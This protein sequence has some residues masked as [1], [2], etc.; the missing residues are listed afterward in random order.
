MRRIRGF[1][2]RL[3]GLLGLRRDDTEL[4][5][6]LEANVALHIEDNIRSGMSPEEARR[7]ALIKWGGLAQTKELYRDR[8]RLPLIEMFFQDVRYGLRMLRKNPGFT[9]VAVLTL[10]LGIGANTAVFSVVRAVLLKSLPYPDPQSLIV[11]NEY[12]VR[13]GE[14]SVSWMDFRDWQEQQ[15]VF[16][17]MAAYRVR[18]FVLTGLEQPDLLR[19]GE[20][21]APFFDL[22]RV[23]PA[24]GRAFGADDD[25]PGANRTVMLSDSFWRSHLNADPA[26]PGRSLILDGEAYTVI[27]ILPADFK[28]LPANIDIFVAAGLLGDDAI[29][30]ERG[31]HEGFEVLA[32]LAPGV[33]LSAARSSMETIMGR[34]EQ[35]YPALD[36]GQRVNLT[37][38]YDARVGDIQR[39][40]WIMLAASF[41]V[42]LI[43]CANV[44]NLSLARAAARARDLAIRGALGARRAR[45]IRQL[46]TENLLLALG[47][48]A[49][50]FVCASWG[51]RPLLL[52]APKS[53]PRLDETRVDMNMFIFALAIALLTGIVFGLLPAWQSSRVDLTSP[54]REAGHRSSTGREGQRLRAVLL[55]A[56]I[57]LA[58]VL[59]T[60]S[61]LLVRSLVRTL[62]VDPGFNA[63]HLLALSVSLPPGKYRTVAQE[64]A[65]LTQALDL[66]R[67]MPGVK[68]A[69]AVSCPPLIGTCWHSVY[70]V[71]DRPAP[72]AAQQPRAAFNIV[73]P[74]YFT[75]MQIPL[76]AGRLFHLS[77][78]Q[79][80]PRVILI[81]ETMA[82]LWWPN[83]SAIG[84]T[85]KQEFPQDKS[86]FM[87]I[88]GV[89]KDLKQEGLD[90]PEW[91]EIFEPVTQ[92]PIRFLT[93][94]VK[95]ANDP[96]S[97]APLVKKAIYQV[98]K[99]QPAYRVQSMD[100]YLAASLA[101][102]K[103]ETLLLGIFSALALLLAAVGVYGLV[104]Y[105]VT[106]RTYEIGIRMALGA[107]KRGI[108]ALVL[109]FGLKLA[110]CGVAIGLAVSFVAT[111][112]L[113]SLLFGV[114]ERDPL[115]FLAVLVLLVLVALLACYFPARNATRVD[116]LMALRSE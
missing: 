113:Q 115:T 114:H 102:R 59:V 37:P 34:L 4:A 72:P 24:L 82:R 58:F 10:G 49:F 107:Q 55:I 87:E 22:L 76:R 51:M 81:N 67:S 52:L 98:D 53:I 60:G 6:E 38:L 92:N 41:C 96:L 70:L 77:D 32:R 46:L 15:R 95:T 101:R 26:V 108:L 1:L 78:Q 7:Q 73:E 42:L 75:T 40:L 84:K 57:S 13:N 48:S 65:F 16:E 50:G 110:A 112:V 66:I 8:T 43:A 39:S 30:R 85:I 109:R 116:P 64:N 47:G 25:K 88:V 99:D 79:G 89:V 19:A 23:R 27:G 62:A 28:F 91:P 103:F 106:Q 83:E 2:L 35:Q 93:F 97:M 90:Q 14:E 18:H 63:D 44:A 9:A 94:V 21:T 111:R 12:H 69:S 61:G 100:D 74:A 68:S 11:L 29:F 45:L 80:S 71:G 3:T 5:E 17:G 36:E 86:A 20:V 105:L 31:N 104:A 56:Q 54:L 33:S